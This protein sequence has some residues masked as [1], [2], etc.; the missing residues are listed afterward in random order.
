MSA[1][2]KIAEAIYKLNPALQPWDGDP[3]AFHEPQARYRR[4]L[5]YK[6]ADAALEALN[7]TE[8]W[9]AGMEDWCGDPEGFDL[10]P[11]IF[12]DR[13]DA[14]R[15]V[16]HWREHGWEGDRSFLVSRFVSQ[17]RRHP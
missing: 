16:Q 13:A 10:D 1:R 11:D 3:F 8:E 4:E 7:L 14:E 2:E 6:Q 15:A 17:W 9:T 12:E 5:A